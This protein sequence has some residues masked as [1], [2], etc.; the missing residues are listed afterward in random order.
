MDAQTLSLFSF[1]WQDIFDILL[2]SYILFRLYVLFRGT[3]IIRMLMA[4]GLLWI[5]ERMARRMGLIVTSWAIQGIIAAAAL[6]VIIVFRNDI[7]GV[8]QARSFKSFFWGITRRQNQTPTEIIADSV[9]EL[10]RHKLGALIVLPVKKGIEEVVHGGVQWQGKLSREMLTSIFWHGTPVHDGAA[11][12]QGNQIVKVAAILPLS[13]NDTLPSYFGTRHRAAVGLTEL[14]DALVIVVSEERGE[15]TVFKDKSIIPV[16]DNIA[17]NRVL[18][19]YVGAVPLKNGARR[20]LLELSLAGLICLAGVTTIWSS[21][22]RGVETFRTLD[23]PVE[24]VN[25]DP[26]MEII[27]ASDSSVKL[28]ISGSGSLIRSIS[29]DQVKVKINLANAEAGKNQVTIARDGIV[30][31]PGIELKQL[32]PQKLEVNLDVPVQKNLPVQPDWTGK[33]PHG[34]LLQEART[35]PETVKVRGGNQTLQNI[36]TIYTEK[37][38]LENITAD[39]KVTVDLVLQPSSLK[40]ADESPKKVEVTFKV[41]RRLPLAGVEGK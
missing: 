38:P 36:R 10:A 33:L 30:L 22:A 14:T 40:L 12:I 41:S 31:P 21:F 6:I 37:I 35:I 18:R 28:Q 29:P 3:N 15:V 13:I 5:L 26:K 8:F 25:R 7:A 11:I 27:S 17:L 20:E 39:G 32:E 23:V 34:L 4:I 2:N 16:K 24:F 9:F 1:R 19:Q